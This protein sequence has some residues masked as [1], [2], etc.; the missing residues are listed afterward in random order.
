[1]NRRPEPS[2]MSSYKQTV[3]KQYSIM[4]WVN[5][6]KEKHLHIVLVSTWADGH[7]V[8]SPLQVSAKV[9]FSLE[10]Y[11]LLLSSFP[12]WPDVSTAPPQSDHSPRS[13]TTCLH[14]PEQEMYTRHVK[15]GVNFLQ[16]SKMI[17][18][19]LSILMLVLTEIPAFLWFCYTRRQ[20]ATAVFLQWI[21]QRINITSFSCLHLTAFLGQRFFPFTP[22][23]KVTR[24][25]VCTFACMW[26]SLERQIHKKWK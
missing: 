12:H 1:M 5:T 11:F 25:S 3:Q 20:Q 18:L 21:F 2:G 6:M 14:L 13:H 8:V 16:G 26:K 19:L 22:R 4:S 24:V 7:E 15:Y 9:N 17:L 10:E 23:F